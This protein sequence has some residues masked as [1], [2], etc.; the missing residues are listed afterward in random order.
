MT[1]Q[2]VRLQSGSGSPLRISV[3]GVDVNSAQFNNLLFDGNQPPLRLW[4]TGYV[5]VAPID[6]L[7]TASAFFTDGPTVPASPSGTIPIF[8]VCVRQPATT[9][10]NPGAVGN[11]NSPPFRTYNSYGMGGGIFNVSGSNVFSGL[12]FNRDNGVSG[13]FAGVPCVVNYAIMKNYQ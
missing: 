4:S 1:T 12:N 3:V 7:N 8:F 11:S 9:A 6:Q 2:R 13:L 5:L 10:P